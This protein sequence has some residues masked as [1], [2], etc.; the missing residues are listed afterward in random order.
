MKRIS[1]ITLALAALVVIVGGLRVYGAY[2]SERDAA[3]ARAAEADKQAARLEAEEQRLDRENKCNEQWQKYDNAKL[4]KR[5]AELRGQIGKTPLEPFCTGYAP[6]L[7][8]AMDLIFK[9][10]EVGLEAIAAREYAKY[11]RNYAA[12]RRLQTRYLGLRL[13][14]FLT[15]TEL[16]QKQAEMERDEEY[17]ANLA[18]CLARAKQDG[19]SKLEATCKETYSKK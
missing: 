10:G 7:D 15:G 1:L 14:A 4:E 18:K 16:K 6:R 8:Q 5:I 17:A 19:D 3:L 13:W 11:E 9:A 2:Q 12:N